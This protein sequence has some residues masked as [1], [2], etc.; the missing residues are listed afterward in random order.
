MRP[1]LRTAAGL[2][3]GLLL[4][5]C[6]NRGV[7]SGPATEPGTGTWVLVSVAVALAIVVLGALL[8]RLHTPAAG[9]DLLASTVLALH[10][11]AALVG[12]AL[13]A[14]L[15][16]RSGPLANAKAAGTPVSE[17]S[18]LRVSVTDGDPR[19]FTLMVVLVVLLGASLTLLLT[20]AARNARNPDPVGRVVACAVLALELPVAA[21]GLARVFLGHHEWPYVLA[22]LHVPV[23]TIAIATCWPRPWGS[24][25]PE[26]RYNLRRG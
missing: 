10:A 8:A 2:S 9:G 14:G 20:V 15:A 3:G 13:L 6:A 21:Y 23:L 25:A 26:T 5:G 11:G 18:L 1:P 24:P 19:F 16:V 7:A 17:V 12:G 4:A 22:A